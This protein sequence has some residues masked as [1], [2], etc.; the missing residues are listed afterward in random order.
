MVVAPVKL[1]SLA[2]NLC[3]PGELIMYP[4][5]VTATLLG[6]FCDLTHTAVQRKGEKN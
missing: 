4:V 1:R 2:H 3:I 5:I 6:A